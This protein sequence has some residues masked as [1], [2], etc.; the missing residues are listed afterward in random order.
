MCSRSESAAMGRW[1]RVSVGLVLLTT[2][3]FGCGGGGGNP[4]TCH[5]SPEVCSGSGGSAVSAT[6]TGSVAQLFSRSGIVD[7]AF[8]LP[9]NVTRI[10]IQASFSGTAQNFVVKANGSP[11]VNAVVGTSVNPSAFDATF[12]VQPGSTVEIVGSDGVSWSIEQAQ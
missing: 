12:S 6:T 9:S 4:G 8:D 3:L 11:L 7:T 1:L 10:R 5:G 2:M